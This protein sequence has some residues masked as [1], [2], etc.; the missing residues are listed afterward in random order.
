MR[1]F[2]MTKDDELTQLSDYL[3]NDEYGKDP[4]I[5]DLG[6]LWLLHYSLVATIEASIYPLFFIEF[7]KEKKEFTRDQLFVFIKRKCSQK[8]SP[9]LYND[10][11][12]KKDIGVLLQNYVIPEECKPYEDFLVLLIDL[13]LI[14]TTDNKYFTINYSTKQRFIPEILLYAIIDKKEDESVITYDELLETALIF[15]LSQVELDEYL[16]ILENKYT[17]ILRFTDDSGI[18]QL[19]FLSNIDKFSVLE[20][21]Y[22]QSN[23]I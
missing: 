2:G 6:T 12:I 18:K 20:N 17:N 16:R 13:N 19:L 22:I 7:Q 4:F 11:T 9:N 1:T 8:N 14:V 21:Y 3:F 10:N 23:E 5:E 15:C